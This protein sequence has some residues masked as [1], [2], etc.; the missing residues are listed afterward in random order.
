M[1]PNK[2]L[3]RSACDRERSIMNQTGH[4]GVQMVRR[5]IGDRL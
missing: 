1:N 5:Y 3:P 2:T 4:R